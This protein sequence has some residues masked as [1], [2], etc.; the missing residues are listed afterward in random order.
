MLQPLVI[1]SQRWE[2]S[3]YFIIGLANSNGKS[4]IMVLVD[5]ITKYAHFYAL[6]HTF[7]DNI[8]AIE[9][10]EKVEKLHENPKIILSDRDSFFTRNFWIK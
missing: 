9:F 4:G 2:V 5:R 8:T 10:M 1:P 7:K 3:L 6:Y